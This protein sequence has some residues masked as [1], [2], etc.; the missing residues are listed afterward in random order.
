ME[1]MNKASTIK[2]SIS[3]TPDVGTTIAGVCIV[4]PTI[5]IVVYPIIGST[6]LINAGDREARFWFI[7]SGTVPILKS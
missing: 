3:G 1:Y 2:E 4:R 7:Q 6:Y 5:G